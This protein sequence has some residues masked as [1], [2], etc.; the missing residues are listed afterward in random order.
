MLS[1]NLSSLK[2]TLQGSHPL[3]D[4]FNIHNCDYLKKRAKLKLWTSNV[5]T[6]E[7]N[8]SLISCLT[9]VYIDILRKITS[10]GFWCHERTWIKDQFWLNCFKS[11]SLLYSSITYMIQM[12]LT[13][14]HQ[15]IQTEP[16]QSF[17]SHHQE[18]WEL[19][20]YKS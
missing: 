12:M 5:S 18:N 7:N 1:I 10:L 17:H 2:Y 6:V 11:I 13:F 16:S 15:Q 8:S 9:M 3:H 20:I 19:E 4:E 14:Y